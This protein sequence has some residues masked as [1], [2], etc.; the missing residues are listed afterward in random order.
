MQPKPSQRKRSATSFVPAAEC[1]ALN[2]LA[3]RARDLDALDEKLR[4]QLPE[5]LARECHLADLRNGRLVFLAT[6]PTWAAR[7]RMHQADLL[8]NARAITGD[9]VEHFVVKV[10]ALPTVPPEPAKRKPLSTAAANHLR[11]AAKTI[12]DPELRDLYISLATLA[13]DEPQTG[14]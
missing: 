11:T 6:S 5:T 8:A 2:T 12:S 14:T 3:K 1:A 10:A 13:S 7:V 9:S 4:H